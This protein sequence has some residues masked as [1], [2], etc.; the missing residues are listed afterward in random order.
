[1]EAVSALA[2]WGRADELRP[3]PDA[4]LI[5]RTW[6]VGE[7]PVA[8]LQWV[9][10]IFRP[11]VHLDIDAITARLDAHGLLT[12]RLLPALDGGLWVEDEGAAW[13]LMSFIPGRTLHRVS[14][15]DVAA[16][17]GALVGR[18]HA[19]VAGWSYNFKHVRVGAHDTPRHMAT[20]LAALGGADGHPLAGAAREV[21]RQILDLWASWEGTLELPERVCHGDL[22]VSNLRFDA[23]GSEAICLLDLDTMASLPLAVE[24]GDAWRSWCNPAG[25]DDP[26]AVRFDLALFEASAAAW[27]AT[28][29]PLSRDERDSLVPGIERICLELSARFCADAVRNTYFREDRA[30]FPDVG[31]HNLFRA[32]GQLRLARSARDQAGAA[33]ALV[34]RAALVS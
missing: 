25:E 4:G 17:C 21:G 19:A 10:P 7:P 12:P 9:N 11:E 13:R 18:F 1:M 6:I 32:R 23:S 28:V 16:A 22:K 5:N 20:L 8:V 31:A 15:P 2:L 33:V 14:G 29:G 27:L 24:M 34:R 30:R 26:E 3:A